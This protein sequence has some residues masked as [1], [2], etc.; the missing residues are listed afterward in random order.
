MPEKFKVFNQ[1]AFEQ[2][3]AA[4]PPEIESVCFGEK[5]PWE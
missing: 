3:A 4:S 2:P 5:P 1:A